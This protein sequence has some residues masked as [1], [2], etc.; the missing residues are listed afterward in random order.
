MLD[1]DFVLEKDSDG[2]LVVQLPESLKDLAPKVVKAVPRLEADLRVLQQFFAK[3]QVPWRFVR[4]SKVLLVLY[5]F[6]NASKAGF[7]ASFE[8]TT[9]VWYRMGMWGADDESESSN[10]CE[11][12]NLVETLECKQQDGELQGHE[13]YFSPIIPQ[14][15]VHTIKAP[16]R[17]RNYLSWCGGCDK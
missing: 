4:G 3:D 1:D 5:G 15:R 17:A 12:C 11:L 8:S 9:G 14:L 10:Y 2:D 7:G 16:P 6:G 13:I